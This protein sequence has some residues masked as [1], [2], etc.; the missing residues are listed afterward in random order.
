MREPRGAAGPV[1]TPL[2]RPGHPS[3][4]RKREPRGAAGPV[5][6]QPTPL[7]L[8]P[9]KDARTTKL[10]GPEHDAPEHSRRDGNARAAIRRKAL[11]PERIEEEKD[12]K[13]AP[14]ELTPAERQ[15]QRKTQTALARAR[16]LWRAH[17]AGPDDANPTTPEHGRGLTPARRRERAGVRVTPLV[18]PDRVAGR[19][20]GFET[21]PHR[22]DAGEGLARGPNRRGGPT[23]PPAGKSAE[24][25]VR[26]RGGF[27][28]RPHPCGAG[29]QET[30]SSFPRRACPVLDTGKTLA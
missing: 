2:T 29:S 16:P 27:E 22:R 7:T 20:G 14:A 3:F 15:N 19:R 21:R 25:A 28:T 8:S 30:P 9:P 18:R 4:P 26:A 23:C 13:P 6:P 12:E 17:R 1:P 24:T 11:G 5:T 10:D